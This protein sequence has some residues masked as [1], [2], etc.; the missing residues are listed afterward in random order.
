[1]KKVRIFH[2]EKNI[3]RGYGLASERPVLVRH[4]GQWI[5]FLDMDNSYR[6]EDISLFI[7]EMDRGDSDFIMGVRSF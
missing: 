4:K 5:G 1:M 2:T 6:P 3:S 7:E